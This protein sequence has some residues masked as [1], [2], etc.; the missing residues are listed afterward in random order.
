MNHAGIEIEQVRATPAQLAELAGLVAAATLNLNTAKGV[1]ETMFRTGRAAGAIVA[2]QGLAQVSDSGEI[3]RVVAQVIA[4]SP[5]ELASYLA[6]KA[7]L[8][9]WFFG[10]VMRQ[11]RGRGNPQVIRLALARALSAAQ[12]DNK[13]HIQPG[14]V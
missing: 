8:E 3:E 6:G 4:A 5:N 12:A 13:E 14:S 7:S 10:Q 11:L 1:F 2:E 9:Q